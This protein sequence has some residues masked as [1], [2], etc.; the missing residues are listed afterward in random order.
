MS[1]STT[2][3]MKP[4]QAGQWDFTPNSSRTPEQL[5]QRFVVAARQLGFEFCGYGARLPLPVTK[6]RI[7]TFS[8]Y[9]L[10]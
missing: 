2:G 9:P 6:P 4:W 7:V 8:N 10:E 5:F 1:G 3:V